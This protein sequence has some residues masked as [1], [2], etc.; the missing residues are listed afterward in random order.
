MWTS[1]VGLFF[2]GSVTYMVRRAP[3]LRLWRYLTFFAQIAFYIPFYFQTVR[4]ESPIGV[5]VRFIPLMLPQILAIV[6]TGGLASQY[7]YYVS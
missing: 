7:G 1:A 2:L 5:G 3:R 6:V 4:G